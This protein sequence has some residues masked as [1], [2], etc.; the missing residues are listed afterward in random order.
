MMHLFL[1]AAAAA[2]ADPFAA[3]QYPVQTRTGKV[4]GGALETPWNYRVVAPNAT[5]VDAPVM[6]FVT[7]LGGLTP[8]DAYTEL[9]SRLASKGVAF[10]GL[11][12]L[13]APAPRRDG[14]SL[15]GAISY[16]KQNVDIDGSTLDWDT[17][18]VSGHSAGN[19]VWCEYLTLSCTASVKGVVMIDP[20]DGVDP[21]GVIPDFC[22]STT[23]KLPY[24]VPALLVS[25]G[26]DPVSVDGTSPPCAPA[27]ISNTR[28]YN[29]WNGPIWLVNATAY[30]HLDACDRDVEVIGRTVC[31]HD[32]AP[33]GP[34][35]DEIAGLVVSFVEVIKG[36][37]TF[38]PYLTNTTRMP[39]HTLATYT[40]NGNQPPFTRGC[41]SV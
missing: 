11:F 25:T 41:H 14:E 26:L 31:A 23:Q 13:A 30:G 33:K 37:A 40:H 8:S 5:G 1:L 10:I 35:K 21:F 20:V 6:L 2:A 18:M 27:N 19:H 16:L 39:V 24:S 32:D 17:F 28:F 36:N 12:R 9:A 29:A 22:T 38:E 4:G 34:Y 3:G 15:I 7:G